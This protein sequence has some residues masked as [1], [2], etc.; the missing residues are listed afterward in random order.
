MKIAVCTSDGNTVDLHFGKTSTFY[1]YDVE[2]GDKNLLEKREV[3]AYCNSENK[4]HGFM[5]DKFEVAYQALK[6]CKK[7]Y[8]ASIG[9]TPKFKFEEKGMEVKLCSC[10]IDAIPTCSGKCK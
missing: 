7:L 3:G 8:T 10:E 9:D 6:D 5:V 1:V 4:E 2:N